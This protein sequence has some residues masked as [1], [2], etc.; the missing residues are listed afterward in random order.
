MTMRVLG[1][2]NL[3]A[4]IM[5]KID[6]PQTLFNLALV[7]PD[8]KETFERCPKQL[9][10]AVLSHQLSEIQLLATLFIALK[11]DHVTRDSMVLLLWGYLRLE[12]TAGLVEPPDAAVDLTIPQE[13]SNPFETLRK[14]AATWIAVEDLASDYVERSMKFI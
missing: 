13:L 14:L 1:D 11:H 12:D 6:N 10:T 8:A 5:E 4:I 2:E 7:L 9:L 3:L